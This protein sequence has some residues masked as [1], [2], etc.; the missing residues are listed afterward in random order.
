MNL[1]IV[2]T[3]TW[4]YDDTVEKSVEIVALD[5]DFWYEIAKSDNRLE[6]GEAPQAP[7]ENGRLYYFRF[8]LI[9]QT[10]LPTWVDSIAYRD[11]ARA[12]KGAEKKVV[13]HIRWSE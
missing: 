5:F 11:I 3:G 6:P 10:D 8:R 4:L 1:E 7:G 12:M 2:K 13:G 9:G